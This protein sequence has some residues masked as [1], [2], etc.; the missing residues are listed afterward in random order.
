MVQVQ[1]KAESLRI[2]ALRRA[3][4]LGALSDFSTRFHREAI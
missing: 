1:S 2:W 4:K 3:Y